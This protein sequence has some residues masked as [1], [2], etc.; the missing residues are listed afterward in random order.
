MSNELQRINTGTV[1]RPTDQLGID[2]EATPIINAEL[3]RRRGV[4][5]RLFPSE[6]DKE[7]FRSHLSVIKTSNEFMEKTLQAF[8]QVKFIALQQVYKDYLIR[9]ATKIS[10]ER[11]AYVM[12]EKAS[13]SD[14][15][16]RIARQFMASMD[17]ELQNLD[18]IKSLALR[19]AEERRIMADVD[20][21][22]DTVARL[23]RD[24][25][26]LLDIEIGNSAPAK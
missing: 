19:Q 11:A 24:F 9:G 18:S 7:I 22:Q 8:C 6:T 21:F 13:L 3:H 20:T 25:R 26:E 12:H 23:M 1:L 17:T 16:N 14:E 5:A 10:S 4:M 2:H 15:I